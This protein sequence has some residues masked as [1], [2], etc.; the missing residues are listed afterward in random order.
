MTTDIPDRDQRLQAI[1]PDRSFIVQAPAGS[2][3]TELL[4]QRYLGLLAQVNSPEE[5][6][7]ITFTRKASAEMQGRV[8]KALANAATDQLPSA[9]HEQLT[10]ELALAALEHGQA[11]EWDILDNPGRLRI[12]TIDSLCTS[13][14]RQM[15]VISGLGGQPEIIDDPAPLYEQAATATLL[16]LESREAWS[17]AI[18][19]LSMHLDNDLPYLK[20]LLMGMLQ[21]RDQWLKHVLQGHDRRTLENSLLNLAREKLE[22]VVSLFPRHLAD[23][24]CEL[25]R[26]AARQLA[27]QGKTSEILHCEAT[28]TLPGSDPEQLKPWQGLAELLLTKQ[29]TWRI[30]VDKSIGFPSPAENKL[31]SEERTRMKQALQGLITQLRDVPGLDTALAGIRQLPPLHFTDAEW[32]LINALNEVLT[33]SATQLQLLFTDRNQMDYS[34]IAQAAIT[35]LGDEE[36]PTDLAMY[37]DYQIKH[38]LVDEFQDTSVNQLALLQG[39]TAQWTQGD[40]RT[41]FL[42]GDPMQSIYRFREA[43]VSNF[44]RTFHQQRLGQIRLEPLVL[45]VNFRSE[46]GIVEWVNNSFSRVFPATED[47]TTGAVSFHPSTAIHDNTDISN[48]NIY[49]FFNDTGDQEA[50]RVAELVKTVKRDST[51]DSVAVLVRNKSHLAAIIPAL[52]DAGLR[53]RAI[54]I[55]SLGDRP[56]IQDIL[57]LTRAWLHLSDRVAWLSLLRAPW[58]GLDLKSLLIIAGEHK[59]RTIRECCRDASLL[60]QLDDASRARL[61]RIMDIF[62]ESFAHRHRRSLRTTIESI[63][64]RLGG[65]ATL[66]DINDLE[67]VNACLELLESLDNG[68][69]IEDFQQLLDEMAGLFAVPDYQAGEDSLQIMTIHKAKGL[70]FDHVIV[71]AL[72]RSTRNPSPELLKWML[73]PREQGGH[74]LFFGIIRET[75]SDESPVYTYIQ[76]VEKMKNAHESARLLY[77]AATRAKKS[78]HLS[79][80]VKLRQDKDGKQAC[81]SAPGSLLSLLWPVVADRWESVMPALSDIDASAEQDPVNSGIRRLTLDWRLPEPPEV[82]NRALLPTRTDVDVPQQIE[83][84]WAGQTIRAIGSI[85]HLCIQVIAKE[86]VE[87][88]DEARVRSGREYYSLLFRQAGV[89]EREIGD[90]CDQVETALVKMLSDSRGRWILSPEHGDQHNEY[91][92]SGLYQNRLVNIIIDRTFIDNDGVRWIIDYKTSRHEG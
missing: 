60:Q 53:F 86:G 22:I 18:A 71:P 20:Q 48:I 67:N 70:E 10:R 63:W 80:S 76:N 90:A 16:E 12:Q 31:E 64:C 13:L 81:T 58:C 68:G 17:S 52:R 2:G 54:E 8:L 30:R 7:A 14:S 38:L 9:H 28:G 36:S 57:A 42:V 34:G 78:L 43:E 46:Q 85:V 84:E 82:I 3:K 29:D 62:D 65:P 55:E 89:P 77:V 11:M 47:L 23:E 83:Y 41:L 72:G 74:D 25:S 73:R 40:G 39:L 56:A 4:I 61:T 44:I 35:A 33:L 87:Q 69:D 26:Y 92:L 91:G 45:T 19:R 15:P 66:S 1:R 51:Q 50:L 79:G 59:H 5:I 49:P 21:K 27:A 32:E 24:L 37:L 88:W 6:I 75:G